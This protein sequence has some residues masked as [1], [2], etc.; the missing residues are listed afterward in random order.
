[1]LTPALL[2]FD[3]VAQEGTLTEAAGKLH[4]SASAISRQINKLETSL[5]MPLFHRHARSTCRSSASPSG[6]RAGTSPCA[7]G[8][9][10]R[11]S[12]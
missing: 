4:V 11:W 12:R 6:R 8:R 5:G 2:Y 3:A 1:M 7:P 10:L 9:P